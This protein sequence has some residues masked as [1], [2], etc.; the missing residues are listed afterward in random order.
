MKLLCKKILVRGREGRQDNLVGGS[1]ADQ[2]K[3][4]KLKLATGGQSSLY[5]EYIKYLLQ[6]DKLIKSSPVALLALLR[7]FINPI[8]IV[9]HR[10]DFPLIRGKHGILTLKLSTYA[11]SKINF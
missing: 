2:C 1:K 4:T 9:L 11:Y 5:Q 10:G 8:Y 3:F 6:K 7:G